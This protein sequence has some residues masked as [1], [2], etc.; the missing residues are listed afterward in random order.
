MRH[1]FSL[2]TSLLTNPHSLLYPH[3]LS[4]GYQHQASHLLTLSGYQI[5]WNMK[6]S[7]VL[8]SEV[9]PEAGNCLIIKMDFSFEY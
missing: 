3:F 1:S 5:P 9:E 6:A 7:L 8:D 4:S 2:D